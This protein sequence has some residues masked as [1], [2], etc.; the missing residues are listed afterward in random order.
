MAELENV[1]DQPTHQFTVYD[2]DISK[3]EEDFLYLLVRR[4]KNPIASC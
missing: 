3:E 2:R 4:S 1:P